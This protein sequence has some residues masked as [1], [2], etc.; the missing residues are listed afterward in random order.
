M[1]K[2]LLFLIVSIPLLAP[3]VLAQENGVC[4][5]YFT[6]DCD[7]CRLTDSFMDGL[8][9]EYSDSLV[10]IKY[11]IDSPGE[12]RNIFEAYRRTYDLPSGIPL[13]LFGKNDYLLGR[14]E[15][16]GK[17]EANIFAY[18][19]QNG[20]NCP[21]ESGYVPPS[22]VSVEELPGQPELYEGSEVPGEGGEEDDETWPGTEGNKTGE[23]EETGETNHEKDI[24]DVQNEYGGIPVSWIFLALTAGILIVL[25]A[26]LM[27]AIKKS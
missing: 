18:L 8:I 19:N 21:L 10:A 26:M 6:G 3:G 9:K 22:E 23:T 11:N 1:K 13:V 16:Y 12:N 7:D 5:V 27:N 4:I 14:S 2:F 25:V 24:E 20:T 15:I 17:A